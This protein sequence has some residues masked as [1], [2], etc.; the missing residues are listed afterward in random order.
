MAVLVLAAGSLVLGAPNS[1]A[2]TL[3]TVASTSAT[4]TSPVATNSATAAN[5]QE[6]LPPTF[7]SAYLD[8][9]DSDVKCPPLS[10]GTYTF[11]NTSPGDDGVQ[12]ELCLPSGIGDGTICYDW[13]LNAPGDSVSDLIVYSG[14]W[15][16]IGGYDWAHHEHVAFS[17]TYTG[18]APVCHAGPYNPCPPAIRGGTP[19]GSSTPAVERCKTLPE[20]QCVAATFATDS[21]SV[22]SPTAQLITAPLLDAVNGVGADRHLIPPGSTIHIDGYTDS[23]GS[24]AYNQQLS[25]RRADAVLAFLQASLGTNYHYVTTGHSY[26]DPV[27]TNTAAAGR[28]QNRRVEISYTKI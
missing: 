5:A 11:E 8:E 19:G 25:I 1:S 27:A 6:G 18:P 22:A 15:V 13:A 2:S 26:N 23:T 16:E 12:L 28:Q 21:S 17:A 20:G 3:A 24:Y 9:W 14:W 10:P 4:T 7:C